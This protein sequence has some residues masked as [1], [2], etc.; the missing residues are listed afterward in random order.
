MARHYYLTRSG[1]LRRRDNT[2]SFEPAAGEQ[3]D[4]EPPP[5]ETEEG[6]A[7]EALATAEIGA[8][9]CEGMGDLAWEPEAE[10]AGDL[11]AEAE[12]ALASEE[13]NERPVSVRERR[14]IPVST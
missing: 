13:E 6:H 1:R 3:H 10:G 5:P 9:A 12:R 4:T 11:T 14:A 2:L 7:A 8:V